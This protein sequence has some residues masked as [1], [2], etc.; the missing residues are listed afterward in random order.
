MAKLAG[1]PVLGGERE[2]L[3]FDR[4]IDTIE[5]KEVYTKKEDGF[6]TV[7]NTERS[8]SFGLNDDHCNHNRCEKEKRK[9]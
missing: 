8:N 1:L 2:K 4:T 7:G 9:C 3:V 6:E 5:E